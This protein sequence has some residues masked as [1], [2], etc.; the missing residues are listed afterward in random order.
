MDWTHFVT[1][2]DC[3]GK[4]ARRVHAPHLTREWRL[5]LTAQG[6]PPDRALRKSRGHSPGSSDLWT[7]PRPARPASLAPHRESSDKSTASTASGSS[8]DFGADSPDIHLDARDFSELPMCL[9]LE[10]SRSS[11]PP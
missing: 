4:S 2:E 6:W 11:V 3:F 5:R 10:P 9:R 8:H 1:E 7:A